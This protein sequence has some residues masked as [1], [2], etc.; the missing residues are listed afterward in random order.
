MKT[1]YL[2]LLA[3]ILFMGGC[4]KCPPAAT[5]T[6]SAAATGHT[7]GQPTTACTLPVVTGGN[8]GDLSVTMTPSGT[9]PACNQ[10]HVF[11]YFIGTTTGTIQ[12][13]TIPAV[14]TN[15][16]FVFTDQPSS[17]ATVVAPQT[18][19]SAALNNTTGAAITESIQARL[20]LNH[21][22][23]VSNGPQL[24]SP[25]DNKIGLDVTTYSDGA[26]GHQIVIV[27]EDGAIML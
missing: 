25:P 14:S 17:G 9:P 23:I 10:I 24:T 8:A 16:Q 2:S 4:C 19:G 22:S 7:S 6:S 27:I 3:I 12:S 1:R 11:V 20:G 18:W 13:V 21:Y 5:P 26:G 15:P